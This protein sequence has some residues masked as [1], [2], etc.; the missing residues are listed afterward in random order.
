MQTPFPNE[1]KKNDAAMSVTLGHAW[2]KELAWTWVAR[3]HQPARNYK[4]HKYASHCSF[5][6][7][8]TI[9]H[10]RRGD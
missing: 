4:Q 9:A 1:S 6:R 3:T 10:S 7:Y 5:T 2:Q 8:V